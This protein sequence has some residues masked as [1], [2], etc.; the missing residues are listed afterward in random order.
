MVRQ[1]FEDWLDQ[2]AEDDDTERAQRLSELFHRSRHNRQK[3]LAEAVDV[4]TRTVQRWLNGGSISKRYWDDLARE[5]DTNVRYLVFGEEDQDVEVDATQL[6][7]IEAKLDAIMVALGLSFDD[8]QTERLEEVIAAA[9]A[10]PRVRRR[11]QP[12]ASAADGPTG[13][14]APAA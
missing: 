8:Q 1:Q 4:E 12:K 3:D 6:D 7:R 11:G 14:A 13:S 2:V 10:L 5:L 9:E